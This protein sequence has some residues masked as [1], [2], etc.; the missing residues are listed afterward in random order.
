MQPAS[1]WFLCPPLFPAPVILVPQP[2]APPDPPPCAMQLAKVPQLSA[3]CRDQLKR[4]MVRW[5]PGC[6]ADWQELRRLP[7]R[8]QAAQL[9][10]A[11]L[12]GTCCACVTSRAVQIKLHRSHD[13]APARC[14][15][16]MTSG[17]SARCCTPAPATCAASA[18]MWR[19][20]REACREGGREGGSA[21][22]KG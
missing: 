3:L 12:L 17:W 22:C 19:W 5:Q 4:V 8:A 11:G 16:P 6:S 1:C 21:R 15:A 20:V 13:D 7:C 2:A 18:R 9:W 14:N 10:L